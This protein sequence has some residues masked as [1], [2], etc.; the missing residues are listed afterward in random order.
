MEIILLANIYQFAEF[1][2]LLSCGSK[3]IFKNAPSNVLIVMWR[4]RFGMVK[5]ANHGMVKNAKLQYLENGTELL[6]EIKKILTCVSDEAFWEV[7][8]L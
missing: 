1:G 8:V 3:D 6:Y 2:D 4:H 5:N 7:I